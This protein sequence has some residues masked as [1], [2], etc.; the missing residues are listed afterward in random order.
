MTAKTNISQSDSWLSVDVFA[1]LVLGGL[2]AFNS[3]EASEILDEIDHWLKRGHSGSLIQDTL[4]W[5]WDKKLV[6]TDDPGTPPIYPRAS[7]IFRSEKGDSV[8][9]FNRN[10]SHQSRLAFGIARIKKRR[11]WKSKEMAA[12][13]GVSEPYMSILARGLSDVKLSMLDRMSRTLNVKLEELLP[14]VFMRDKKES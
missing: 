6:Q 11:G 3:S 12:A 2:P 10:L 8:V 14:Y 7:V 1:M 13:L 4:E 9:A 5:L